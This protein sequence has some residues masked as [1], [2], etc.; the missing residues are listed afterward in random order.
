MEFGVGRLIDV[1]EGPNIRQSWDGGRAL[2]E[3]PDL[4][5]DAFVTKPVFPEPASTLGAPTAYCAASVKA[6]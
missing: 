1:R 5:L 2:G 6:A 4:R 3:S